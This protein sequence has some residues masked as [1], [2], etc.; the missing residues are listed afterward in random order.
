MK[1]FYVKIR[2]SDGST[3]WVT[4]EA[5]SQSDARSRVVKDGGG[6]F[7]PLGVYDDLDSASEEEQ[8]MG[9]IAGMLALEKAIPTW[10]TFRPSKPGA[11]GGEGGNEFE[12]FEV[13]QK[14]EVGGGYGER[15]LDKKPPATLSPGEGGSYTNLENPQ[16]LATRRQ[17]L[18]QAGAF[19]AF[20]E[21]L[22]R[23]GYG[24]MGGVAGRFLGNQYQPLSR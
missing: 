13:E 24:N 12:S 1:K 15:D 20:L 10:D 4:V 3:S 7:I 23:A 17:E 6:A 11:P 14:R 8:S 22:D 18:E 21:E 19:T 16:D 9:N 2:A 5:T